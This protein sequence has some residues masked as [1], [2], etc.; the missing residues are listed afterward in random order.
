MTRNH[1]FAWKY[2]TWIKAATIE[3]K[4]SKGGD[5]SLHLA[6]RETGFTY[7]F[8]Q[9]VRTTGGAY[10]GSHALSA[11]AQSEFS[12]S[13]QAPMLRP[14]LVESAARSTIELSVEG[15]ETG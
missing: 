4:S 10:F 9:R 5:N 15:R 7:S 2:R 11:G 12:T 14:S 13:H 3:F 8:A 1:P 6:N